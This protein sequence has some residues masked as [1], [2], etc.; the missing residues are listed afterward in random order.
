MSEERFAAIDRRL[1]ELREILGDKVG[2]CHER[3]NEALAPEPVWAKPLRWFLGAMGF[4]VFL[5]TAGWL[6]MKGFLPENFVSNFI[7]GVMRA[8]NERVAP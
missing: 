4:L 1:D 2:E 8:A 3:I 6:A 5:G 7:D